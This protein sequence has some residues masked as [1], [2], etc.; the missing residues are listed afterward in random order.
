MARRSLDGPRE[1]LVSQGPRALADDELLAI[2]LGTGCA[3]R[4][5]RGLAQAMLAGGGLAALARAS[6]REL[7]SRPGI[8]AAKAATVLA[9][10]ELGRRLATRRLREGD[11]IRGPED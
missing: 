9:A 5:A 7:R 11:A 4:S 3:G 10:V 8:G 6:A 1:R 2:L